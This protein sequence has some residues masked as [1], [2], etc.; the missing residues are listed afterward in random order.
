[1]PRKKNLNSH[2]CCVALLILK[3]LPQA[4]LK[5]SNPQ[6]KDHYQHLHS[7]SWRNI[8]LGRNAFSVLI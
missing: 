3:N 1:M 7:L 6:L 4:Y 8:I 5:E 2:A